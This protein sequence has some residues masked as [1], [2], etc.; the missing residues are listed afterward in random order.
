MMYKKI[1]LLTGSEGLLGKS[2]VDMLSEKYF[3]I[4]LDLKIVGKKFE[5]NKFEKFKADITKE[6]EL[7]KIIKIIN[8]KYRIIDV[9]LNCAVKQNFLQIEKQTF[10]SFVESINTNIGGVFLTIK[11]FIPLLRKSTAPLIINLGSI[12]GIVSGNPGIYTDK[13]RNTSDAYAASKAAIIQLTK[14]Y[15]VHLSKY[16]IRVNCISPGGI[17]NNQGKNFIKN[18]SKK[19]PTG[20]MAKKEEIVQGIKILID[21]E[22]KYINGHNLVID[23]GFTVW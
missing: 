7:K 2:V 11:N 21:D 17:E 1:V 19:T 10:K 14:Y 15:A 13:K 6:K 8:H 5:K 9:L 18:Y 20:R 12:Y 16:K 22:C 4:G 3:I 23:G